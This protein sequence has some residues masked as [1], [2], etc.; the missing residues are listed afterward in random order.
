MPSR[1]PKLSGSTQKRLVHFDVIKEGN[2][3]E[4]KRDE[5]IFEIEIKL[6]NSHRDLQRS[7]FCHWEPCRMILEIKTHFMK[8]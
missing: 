6:I 7:E 2:T 4:T 3:R 8:V 5:S 1:N